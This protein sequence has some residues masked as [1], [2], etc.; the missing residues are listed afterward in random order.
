[1]PDRLIDPRVYEASGITAS[2]TSGSRN[3]IVGD[4]GKYCIVDHIA[5]P[6]L[7]YVPFVFDQATGRPN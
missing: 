3:L 4:M 5:G 1:M 6:A 7:E 2:T